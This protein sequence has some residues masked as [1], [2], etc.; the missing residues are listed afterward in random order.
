[1][2]RPLVFI[3]ALISLFC[4]TPAVSAQEK[5]ITKPVEILLRDAHMVPVPN[6]TLR[7]TFTKTVFEKKNVFS[8]KRTDSPVEFSCVSNALGVCAVE[9]VL[10]APRWRDEF[11]EISGEIVSV[12]M[13]GAE[14]PA[15]VKLALLRPI[16]Y[17]EVAGTAFPFYLTQGADGFAVSKLLSILS[18]EA[19]AKNISVVGDK[20]FSVLSS[21]PMAIKSRDALGQQA[22]ST[23]QDVVDSTTGVHTFR[24]VTFIRINADM[25][26]ADTINVA[27]KRPTVQRTP[28]DA[29][30]KGATGSVIF[31]VT[32]TSVE[33]KEATGYLDEW[34]KF[35]V[36]ESF[37]K[38]LLVDYVPLADDV[39]EFTI[40]DNEGKPKVQVIPYFAIAGLLRRA[41]E[42]RGH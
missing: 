28:R 12:Q 1:M 22:A 7:G 17:V 16:N 36:E 24:I 19:A 20:R 4:L 3:A 15:V 9:A 5:L 11:D 38:S 42:L 37:L 27:I 8:T 35:T 6:V 21:G 31:P 2:A 26:I 34:V 30:Y 23:L 10:K 32:R 33:A 18:P 14:A 25:T 41:G 29:V 40:P 39:L 13:P